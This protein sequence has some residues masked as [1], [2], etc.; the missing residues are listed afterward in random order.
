MTDTIDAILTSNTLRNTP[1][2]NEE[3]YESFTVSAEEA[4]Q[5]LGVNRS[6]LSQ[7]TSKGV[8]NFEKR[9]IDTRNRLFYKL[10]ELLN[11]QRNQYQQNYNQL[12]IN[13][14]QNKSYYTEHDHNKETNKETA[15]EKPAISKKEMSKRSEKKIQSA[16]SLY[17]LEKQTQFDEKIM[18]NIAKLSENIQK[19][20]E[21][22]QQQTEI[23]FK[24]QNF[25]HKKLMQQENY[26]KKI[27]ENINKVNI[28]LTNLKD[29]CDKLQAH[30]QEITKKRWKQKKPKYHPRVAKY[31]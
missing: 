31:K 20:I 8:F 3:Q 18:V 5:L 14:Q 15:Q 27:A 29:D 25:F 22:M 7:L 1:Y 10:S 9:K 30:S 19:T 21:Y 12:A 13:I 2:E 28:S 23:N 11:H 24:E 26:N 16:Y 6:R 4:A 17:Q